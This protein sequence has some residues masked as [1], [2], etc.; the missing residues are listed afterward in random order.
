MK[1]AYTFSPYCPASCWDLRP[2]KLS[3]VAI[4][5]RRNTVTAHG[6]IWQFTSK[7]ATTIVKIS[8]LIRSFKSPLYRHV[9]LS[10]ISKRSSEWLAPEIPSTDLNKSTKFTQHCVVPLAFRKRQAHFYNTLCV[11]VYWKRHASEPLGPST[12]G[13]GQPTATNRDSEGLGS[14]KLHKISLIQLR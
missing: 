8:A 3:L 2:A 10:G 11:W 5:G 9:P 12:C 14:I 1:K 6:H 7:C 13:T 4:K